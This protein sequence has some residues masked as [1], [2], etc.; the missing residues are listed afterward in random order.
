MSNKV[1]LAE[2]NK[3]SESRLIQPTD[4]AMVKKANYGDDGLWDTGGLS[5]AQTSVKT[6][7]K[8]TKGMTSFIKGLAKSDLK[9]AKK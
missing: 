3:I 4:L 2:V 7:T 8:A 1:K 9:A 6:K 5:L